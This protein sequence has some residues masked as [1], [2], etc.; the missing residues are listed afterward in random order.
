MAKISINA[1][2]I[3]DYIQ[4]GY[5]HLIASGSNGS[6]GSSTGYHLRWSLLGNL[7]DKHLPKGNLSTGGNY[8]TS[9][10]YNKTGDD[11]TVY[12]AVYDANAYRTKVNFQNAPNSITVSGTVREWQ[13]DNLIPVSSV[14][15][16]TNS[17]IIR[18]PDVALYDYCASQF[19]PASSPLDFLMNYSGVVEALVVGKSFFSA[20]FTLTANSNFTAVTAFRCEAVATPSSLN[21]DETIVCHR[22]NETAK[23]TTSE[24]KGENISYVRY[25]HTAQHVTEIEFQCYHDY[26]LGVNQHTAAGAWTK[27]DSLS[28][29]VS[30]AEVATRLEDSGRFTINNTWPR[31]IERNSSTGA[32]TVKRANYLDKWSPTADP[33]SGIKGALINY[34]T[35]SV[36]DVYA[37]AS[38]ASD[39]Q[40]DSTHF[41]ISYLN[42]LKYMAIDFHVARMLGLGYIDTPVENLTYIYAATYRTLKDPSDETVTLATSHVSLSLPTAQS[43]YRLPLEPSLEN[44]SYGLSIANG[45]GSPTQ[46]SDQNGYALYDDV[47]FVNINKKE[48]PFEKPTGQVIK[49][50]PV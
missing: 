3:T 15:A 34:L 20:R 43:S 50:R 21:P 14:P 46:L 38:L 16:N 25:N 31:Y 29:S 49:T 37:N 27:V 36:T 33:G 45:S 11:L 40:G 8:Q 13:Y 2:G 19:D 23:I 12:R 41:D 6:D 7:G 4:Q 5:L 48:Y 24:A 30:D 1:P 42:L 47:R 22:I 9:L 17:V 44:I 35:G 10:A 18:F 26:V 39:L 32:Y 28:L